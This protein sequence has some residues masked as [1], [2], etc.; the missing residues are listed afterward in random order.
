[1]LA[2][3][4]M[5]SVEDRATILAAM[6]T[7]RNAFLAEGRVISDGDHELCLV[8]K[9]DVWL[10]A[11]QWRQAE[12]PFYSVLGQMSAPA[13]EIVEINPPKQGLPGNNRGLIGRDAEGKLWLLR[14][15][16]IQ[17]PGGVRN[18]ESLEAQPDLQVQVRLSNG[19]SKTYYKVAC[20]E[21]S[22]AEIVRQTKDFVARAAKLRERPAPDPLQEQ[23]SRLPGTA[24][25]RLNIRPQG[26]DKVLEVVDEDQIAIG[27]SEA[28]TLVSPEVQ[29]SEFRDILHAAY[30][31]RVHPGKSAGEMQRFLQR[32]K[33]GD[34]VLVPHS[35]GVYVGRVLSDPVYYPEL[36]DHDT[37]FRRNVAWLKGG[38][39]YEKASF[40][41]DTVASLNARGTCI[42][43]EKHRDAI[44]DVIYSDWQAL[45]VIL[46]AEVNG[47]GITSP[48]YSLIQA[49]PEQIYFRQRLMEMYGERCCLTGTTIV[50]IL[51][52]AH[53]SPHHMGGPRVNHPENGLLLRADIHGLFD[54]KLLSVD[55]QT[56]TICLAPSIA[57][58]PEYAFLHGK[59]VHLH[60]H[61]SRLG[62]H[63]DEAQ[64]SW[65][66]LWPD[67]STS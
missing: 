21:G 65:K 66:T 14:T 11:G 48:S 63:F 54:R 62:Q 3:V 24:F 19:N 30:G 40:T 47:T 34:V 44:L 35:S 9:L 5:L 42:T 18:L 53:I 8:P 27:W 20:L 10:K 43:L 46:D 29:E 59:K 61:G 57:E 49:R 28:A 38:K 52:A 33:I 7:W 2:V 16:A 36:V 37:A 4:E 1:M 22:S 13:D 6:S 26:I 41:D 58:C 51:Q 56:M 15:G 50:D 64:R 67:V 25:Y 12:M 32:M 60:A 55:P 39:P 17:V 31:D 23:I 45:S